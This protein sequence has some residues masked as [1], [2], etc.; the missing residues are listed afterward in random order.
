[1]PEESKLHDGLPEALWKLGEW[2]ITEFTNEK[3]G[4]TVRGRFRLLPFQKLDAEQTRFLLTFLRCRGILSCVEKELGISYPTA[5]SRLDALLKALD[6]H[7][8][9]EFA[10]SEQRRVILEKQKE[11]LEKLETGEITP[12]EAKKAM[13]EASK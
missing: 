13:R 7:P 12:E 11:I 10:A 4:L 8:S 2:M 9:V 5:R 1:M 6:L 3:A